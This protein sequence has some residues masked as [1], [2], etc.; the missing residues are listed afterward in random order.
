MRASGILLGSVIANIVG[1]YAFNLICIRWLGS[2]D[3]AAVAA[4]TAIVTI[5][6]LPLLGVQSAIAREVAAFSAA[7]DAQ[8]NAALLRLTARRTLM[9]TTAGT[10]LFLVLSP[11]LQ[12][13][14]GIHGL[15]P[16]VAAAFVAATG[17]PLPILQGFL[18]GVDRFGQ[19]T[20]ALVSYA[21]GR[22]LLTMPLIVAGLGVTGAL[23]A[24]AIAS[25]V[26]A[27]LALRG[28]ADLLTTPTDGYVQIELKGF[29]P[30]I[31]GLLGFTLLTNLDVIAA[32]VFLDD[33][34]AGTY[35][36]ASLVGKLAALLPAGAIAPV[37]LPR[38]TGRIERGE[39]PRPIVAISLLATL[40]FGAALTLVLLPVPEAL[41]VSVFGAQFSGARDLLAPCAAAMTLCGLI[42]VGLAFAFALRDR[43]LVILVCVGVGLQVALLSV[44][45]QSPYQILAATSIAAG[46]VIVLHEIL[47]PTAARRLLRG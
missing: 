33:H 18:Q 8:R 1:A 15:W 26:A 35:A 12:S 2:R 43:S 9:W 27:A 17:V 11:L 23:S 41:V 7:G 13:L 14:L 42:N 4:L 32:K 46:A 5:V 31:V 34:E 10:V 28:L 20:I 6:L 39:D 30:V 38:A 25:V 40:L 22:P 19:I 44:L 29:V 3:Y 16:V 36:A 47:S 37:L 21:L 45:N 24:G